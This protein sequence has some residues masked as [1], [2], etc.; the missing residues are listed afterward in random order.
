MKP[1]VV[2]QAEMDKL[3]LKQWQSRVWMRQNP[4]AHAMNLKVRRYF[5]ERIREQ[6]NE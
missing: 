2:T 3:L 1:Q 6:S 4:F 5:R